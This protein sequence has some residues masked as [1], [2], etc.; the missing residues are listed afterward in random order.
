MKRSTS[1]S[2]R[3]NYIAYAFDRLN[4]KN[5]TCL[6]TLTAQ[7]AQIQAGNPEEQAET[8][9]RAKNIVQPK[10]ESGKEP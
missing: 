2:E 4:P 8:R 1:K 10:K 6:E 9:K 3:K 5:Q 7:L